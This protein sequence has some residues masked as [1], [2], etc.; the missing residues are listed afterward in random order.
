MNRPLLPLI[1]LPRVMPAARIV[2]QPE[3]RA[4]VKD[5]N[6]CRYERT[7]MA[8]APCNSCQRSG[9]DTIVNQWVPK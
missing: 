1:G 8:Q 5:C 3:L 6:T 2:H 4:P 7:P 9:V